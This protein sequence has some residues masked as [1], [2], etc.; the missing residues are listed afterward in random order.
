MVLS[1]SGWRLT[2]ASHLTLDVPTGM[3]VQ[4]PTL[5]GDDG[6]GSRDERMLADVGCEIATDLQPRLTTTSDLHRS[7][8]S[9]QISPRIL[10]TPVDRTG[11]AGGRDAYPITVMTMRVVP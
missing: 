6:P 7:R 8:P 2:P 1:C 4:P 3:G 11:R 9:R 5:G 10:R